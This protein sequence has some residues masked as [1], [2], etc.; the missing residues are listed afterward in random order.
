[1]RHQLTEGDYCL[2]HRSHIEHCPD[3]DRCTSCK[4]P[5]ADHWNCPTKGPVCWCSHTDCHEVIHVRTSGPITRLAVRC[6]QCGPLET[7]HSRDEVTV[8]R[9]KHHA[10]V[11]GGNVA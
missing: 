1:M 3:D 5:T 11:T 7:V 9:V 2:T 4:R 6:R 10:I 8:L